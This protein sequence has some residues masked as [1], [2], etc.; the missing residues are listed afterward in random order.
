MSNEVLQ[1]PE[2]LTRLITGER[3]AFSELVD[4]TSPR[5]YAL[6]LRMLGN[7]QDAEDV[8][9][10]T[11][12]KAFRAL[13]TFEGRSSLETWL[14]RIAANEALML[15]RKGKKSSADLDLDADKP[16]QEEAPEIVDWCCVPEHELMNSETRIM[17]EKA[18][19]SLSPNLRMVFLLREIQDFSV[20]ETAEILGVS[21]DVVKTRL[22]R[23]RLK[24]REELSV[25]FRERMGSEVHDG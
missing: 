1:S 16:E 7:E 6:G 18:A 19:G 12:I 5:I 13:K 8:L 3:E 2:F 11:Y 4:L 9:Q 22:V 10:E 15:L 21:E 25:Y 23:A 24:L 14:F 17:L 20:K